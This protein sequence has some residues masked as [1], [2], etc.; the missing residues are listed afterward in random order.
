MIVIIDYG[1]GNLGSLLNM[2]KKLNIK[3]II[4]SDANEIGSADKLILPGVGSFDHGIHNL[5][6]YELLHILNKRVIEE[7][8][9][10]LGICL[11]MQL[12]TKTSEEGVMQGLGWLDAV[13]IKF[14]FDTR[15]NIKIPHMGWDSIKI[16]K[17]NQIFNNL[18]EESMFYFVHSYHVVCKDPAD[19][20]STTYYG[21]DFVSSLSRDNIIGVQFHPEK[22]H[23][24]G[25]KVLE[26]FSI[27]S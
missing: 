18:P 23:K 26:N 16:S 15:L 10:I 11:G 20:L 5:K 8:T 14:R 27:M 9:P 1:I 21:Y 6:K 25:M 22:S 2:L 17:R 19:V 4:S 12:F 24:Y 7:K 13:T 3:S